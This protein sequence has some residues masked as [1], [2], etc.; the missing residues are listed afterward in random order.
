MRPSFLMPGVLGALLA[1]CG[2]GAEPGP[3]DAGDVF[4]AFQSSF[5][6]YRTWESFQVDGHVQGVSHL[7]GPRTVYL[8]A[9]PPKGSTAFPIGTRIVKEMNDGSAQVFAMAKRGGGYN[10]TGAHDWEWFELKLVEADQ[11][12][13]QWRGVGP[14][15]GEKYAGDPNGGCNGCHVG[16]EPNDYVS[17]VKL[18]DL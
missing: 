9:R 18:A 11:L 2:P 14:P 6:G 17:S 12:R 16:S 4:V 1:A 3:A 7:A 13:I 5:E 8:S 10:P 15:A